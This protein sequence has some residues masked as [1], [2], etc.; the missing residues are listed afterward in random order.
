MG[1]SQGIEENVYTP[2]QNVKVYPN[3]TTGIVKVENAENATISVYTLTGS[4]VK[5][6]ESNAVNTSFD[7][8]GLAK[9]TYLVKVIKENEVV[10]KKINLLK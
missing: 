9:G 5:T 1:V 6:I 7:L 10:T 4:L 3:P 8:T 2:S